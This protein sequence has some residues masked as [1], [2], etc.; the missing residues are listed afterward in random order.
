M[1]SRSAGGH[2]AESTWDDD[3]GPMQCL[4]C[5]SWVRQ[6]SIHLRTQH[7]LGVKE[8]RQPYG[9]HRTLPETIASLP[10]NEADPADSMPDGKPVYGRPGVLAYDETADRVQCHF[11]GRWYRVLSVHVTIHLMSAD[12]YRQTY[13]S[14]IPSPFAPRPSRCKDAGQP[15]KRRQGVV[16]NRTSRNGALRGRTIGRTVKREMTS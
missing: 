16:V 6:I 1:R 7:G 2:V 9:E 13:V 15:E 10:L 3:T 5:G 8:Y 4:D 12:E 11:C 14:I